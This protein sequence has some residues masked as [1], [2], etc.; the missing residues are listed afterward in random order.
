EPDGSTDRLNLTIRFRS[1]RRRRH[2]RQVNLNADA[3][4]YNESEFSAWGSVGRLI[5]PCSINDAQAEEDSEGNFVSIAKG[6]F[7]RGSLRRSLL[8]CRGS[9]RRSLLI[10]RGSLRRSLLFASDA[11]VASTERRPAKQLLCHY[12]ARAS[13]RRSDQR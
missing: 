6:L 11:S 5:E 13:D 2:L 9:L 10:C 8:F 4:S 3:T 7:C 1:L 12:D